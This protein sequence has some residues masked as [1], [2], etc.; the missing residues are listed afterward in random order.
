M[1]IIDEVNEVPY[2]QADFLANG[3]NKT[4]LIRLIS[5]YLV[6]DGQTVYQCEGDSDTKIVATSLQLTKDKY[7]PIVVV[8]DDTDIAVMLLYHC[9]QSIQDIFFHQEKGKKSWCI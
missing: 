5:H 4:Q 8:A 2:N 9:N 3:G 1:V 7:V 6:Q